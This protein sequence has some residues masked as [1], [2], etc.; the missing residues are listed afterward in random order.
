[1]LERLRQQKQEQVLISWT[2]ISLNKALEQSW[3]FTETV[4]SPLMSQK[5][6][7]LLHS[8]IPNDAL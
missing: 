4:K 7:Y 6:R 8:R 3:D 1:M 2:L 5:F